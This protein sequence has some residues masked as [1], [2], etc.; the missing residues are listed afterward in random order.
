M[1]NSKRLL[2]LAVS[3]ALAAPMA[4]YATNGMNL[5]GYGPIAT[6][7]GGA[8]MAY[9]NGTAAVM[10]NPATLGMMDDG[11][12]LDVALGFLGPKV[13]AS[14]KGN[15]AEWDS[16]SNSFFMPAVGYM[17]KKGD[18]AYGVGMFA[19]GGMGTEYD[20]QGGMYGASPGGAMSGMWI[21]N[22]SG[23]ATNPSPTDM[24]TLLT[25]AHPNPAVGNL[26]DADPSGNSIGAAAGLAGALKERSEVGVGRLVFPFVKNVGK[27]SVGGSVDYVWAGMD[28]QMAMAGDMMGSMMQS[29]AISGSLV[30]GMMGLMAYNPD[31]TYNTNNPF[32]NPLGAGGVAPATAG[33]V[34]LNYGYFDFTDSSDYTGEA[35]GAG[36]AGKLG[37]TYKV[38]SKL[39]VGGTLHTKTSM[40]DLEASGA[41]VTMNVLF[42]DDYNGVVMQMPMT[43][44]GTM[45]VVD[46]QWPQTIGLG[47]SYQV[48]DKLMIAGDIKSIGWS[49]VMKDFKMSFTADSSGNDFTQAGMPANA[50]NMNGASMDA[51]MAQDWENQTVI[52]IGGAY[53]VAPTTV[54]RAGYNKASN[55][56]PTDTVNYLFPAI[57]VTHYTL[58]VGHAFSKADSVDFSLTMAP[59][60]TSDMG[61]SAEIS[62]G[63]TNWQM[64]YSKK[65]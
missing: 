42:E 49:D 17:K 21:G 65:F 56:I 58:G 41:K 48:N 52:A 18:M 10:N 12:R 4:A 64:M 29:G 31:G 53:Q 61:S 7:M 45:K 50:M 39:N 63:Q 24:Y 26:A 28:L 57:Q 38:N 13:N 23:D 20:D 47:A 54:V 60:H 62:M 37:F 15:P 8:S 3:A 14:V 46:F 34:G 40:S 6:G 33:I 30:N 19:Q 51:T 35:K 5:E 36:F 25:T 9:D 59:E 11:S 44:T 27:L 43:L 22:T 55:P 2:A 32:Y 16:S 1:N